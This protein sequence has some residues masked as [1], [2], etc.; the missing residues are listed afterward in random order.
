[1]EA[2]GPIDIRTHGEAMV[3]LKGNLDAHLGPDGAN[4]DLKGRAGLVADLETNAEM[5]P[6]NIT[7]QDTLLVGAEAGLGA[8]IGPEGA[9]AEAGGFV[10]AKAGSEHTFKAFGVELTVGGD[11]RAGVGGEAEAHAGLEDGT[12]DLGAHASRAI[13]LGAGAGLDLKVD[14]EKFT[15]SMGD[16]AKAI[17]SNWPGSGP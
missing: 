7:R 10:G 5:G 9:K 11:V 12:W 8:S 17:K 2:V 13:G 16:L 15:D 1:V 14:P 6:V 4:L 3:G